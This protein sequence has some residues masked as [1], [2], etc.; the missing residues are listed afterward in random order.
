MLSQKPQGKRY[1]ELRREFSGAVL[2]TKNHQDHQ[3]GVNDNTDE[4]DAKIF[5]VRGSPRCPLPTMQNFLSHPG[6]DCLIQR[7]R[8][9]IPKK[10]AR[11]R[12]R[13]EE[14]DCV[15]THPRA[16]KHCPT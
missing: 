10:K 15:V 1:F 13:E 2:L 11:R 3:G 5:E 16:K 8:D 4:A 6:L 7:P 12:K 9:V 14:S